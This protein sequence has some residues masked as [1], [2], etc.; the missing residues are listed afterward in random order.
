MQIGLVRGD[1]R[2][3]CEEIKKVKCDTIQT[4]LLSAFRLADSCQEL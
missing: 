3:H 2:M 4:I 1:S